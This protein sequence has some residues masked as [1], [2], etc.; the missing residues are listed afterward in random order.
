MSS[1]ALMP[2]DFTRPRPGV[3]RTLGVLNLVIAVS[4]LACVSSS[5]IWVFL[6]SHATVKAPAAKHEATDP[7]GEG[8]KGG[9]DADSLGV[10]GM[11]DPGFIRFTIVD[12]ATALILNG[13]MFVS[14][15]GLVN[16]RPWGARLWAWLAWIKI[17]RLSLLWGAFIVV[18]G[19]SLTERMAR[20]F[21]ATSPVRTVRAP[22][23][24]QMTRPL[25][26]MSLIMAIGMI[27]VGSIYPA[28]S[29]WLL[30]RPGVRSALD[31]P[32]PPEA[33]PT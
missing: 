17:V 33:N 4:T 23:P 6:A 20:Y 24:G 15:V 12:C 3:A 29:L 26:V 13:L 2:E 16:L 19:P 27:V 11:D 9:A 1:V 32:S 31:K 21:I 28:V 5:S 22:L 8:P 14:G 30:G 10:F 25:A 18:V 7:P